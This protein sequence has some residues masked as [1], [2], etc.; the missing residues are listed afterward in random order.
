MIEFRN[1]YKEY[2]S[3]QLVLKDFNLTCE[4]GEITVLI[5][6]SGCGKSTTIKLTNRLI[7]PTKGKIFVNGEDISKQVPVK[8]RRNIGYVIQNI[9]LFPH[10]TNAKNVSVVPQLKN[11]MKIASKKELVS[12]LIW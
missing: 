4:E 9:S 5:G 2:E 8:L 10:M 7:N 1:I 11:G 6:P 3:N 12:F